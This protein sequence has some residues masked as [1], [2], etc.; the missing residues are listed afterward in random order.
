[1]TYK[2]FGTTV[3]GRKLTA[4][5]IGSGSKVISVDCG[6]HAREW[7]SPAY[8]QWFIN[9]AISGRFAQY[10]SSVKFLVQPVLNPDGYVYTWNS[11]RMWRKNRAQSSAQCFGIDLNRNYDANFGGPGSSAQPCSD[12]YRGTSAA[13][14]LETKA[15]VNYLAPYIDD[16]SLKAFLTF[17][18]YGQY[19]LYPYAYDFTSVPPNKDELNTLGQNMNLAIFQKH[20]KRY[21]MGQ[22]TDT[23]YPAAGGSD[24]WAFDAMLNAGNSGPLSYTL[25]LRDTGTYGFILPASQIE[26]N[27]EE[28][29]EGMDVIIKYVIDNK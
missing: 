1:V 8:C 20:N 13:S 26:P 18:S 21:T 15:Q 22:T 27:A 6:I 12:T 10:T 29:D 24:D 28:M 19:I 16:K 4:L 2:E 11:Q 23:L 7:V 17:H 3:E 5:E 9:E 25:E 14:E